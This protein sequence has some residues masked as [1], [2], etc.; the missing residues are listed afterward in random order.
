MYVVDSTD[1]ADDDPQHGHGD[2]PVDPRAQVRRDR[3][4]QALDQHLSSAGHPS[5]RREDG[6]PRDCPSYAQGCLQDCN[7]RQQCMLS[8]AHAC[9]H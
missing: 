4:L 8:V 5:S 9:M 1:G 2:D 6:D 3:D 7:G